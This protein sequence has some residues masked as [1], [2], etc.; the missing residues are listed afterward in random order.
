MHNPIH[1]HSDPELHWTTTNV[2]EAAPGVQTPL[3]WT[4]WEVGDAALRKMAHELGVLTT[5]EQTSSAP[6]A[7]VF[8]VFYGRSALKVEFFVLLGDR[9]PGATGEEVAAGILGRSAD[10]ITY[11]PTK[12]RYPSIARRLPRVFV[13]AP[14]SLRRFADDTEAWYHA[15]LSE[16]DDADAATARS[17]LRDAADRLEAALTIQAIV[18]FGVV[19]PVY[20]ALER[21]VSRAG[22]GDV[23]VLSGSG[24]AEVS[25][26]LADVWAA[27]R[28]QLDLD[29]V[30][31][32]HG[33]H[34]PAEGELSSKVWRDE[35]EP[36][37]K[38]IREYRELAPDADPALREAARRN[39]RREMVSQVLSACPRWQR[40]VARILLNLA[41]DRIPLRGVAKRCMLQAFDVARAASARLAGHLT[42][43]GVL[44]DTSDVYY[45]TLEE[46]LATE[47]G[48]A[49][50]VVAQR[51]ADRARYEA[52]DIPSEWKGIPEVIDRASA[53]A[54]DDRRLI[55]GIGVS[56]G[57]VEGAA[58]VVLDP[59][60]DIEPGEILVSTTTDPSWATLMMV[61]SALVVDIGGAL[62][63][64]AV[65]A[66]EL[67][68]PCV[69][70]TRD[71]TRAIRTGDHLRVDGQTGTVEILSRQTVQPT[72]D[73]R[74]E[75]PSSGS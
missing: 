20:G 71:G 69:V 33:F 44:A 19:Q 35:P 50:A 57:I 36:L 72:P 9:M 13:T 70:N 23:G 74:A 8:Q 53:P 41:A 4:L 28:D 75:E 14:R 11:Q 22:C 48:D 51:R 40:A 43:A 58:H 67:G 63:H 34:G 37:R 59:D 68:I 17:V 10:D 24:G 6:D 7:P 25:G 16:L 21:L 26:M 12:R 47:S 3:S 18:A 54:D 31:R 46:L 29:E 55:E 62:S 73:R 5:A 61:S 1:S 60:F 32:R 38:R 45:L 49:T 30:V 39:E 42:D 66:R 15:R 64:A 2:G 52:F 56:S 27:S 65:V